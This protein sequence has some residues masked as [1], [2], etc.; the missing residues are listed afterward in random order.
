VH[1][2]AGP[3]RELLADLY[4]AADLFVTAS[5]SHFETFGRAPAE[6]L[7]CGLPVVAP[8]YDGFAEVLAQPGGTLVDVHVDEATGVPH[9]AGELLL[10]AV[11]DVLSSPRPPRDDV[12]SAALRRFG[13]SG[14]IRLL[15]YLAG[16]PSRDPAGWNGV[17]SR[18]ELPRE[19]RQPLA[20]MGTGAPV[21]ALRWFWHDCDQAGLSSLTVSSRCASAGRCACHRREWRRS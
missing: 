8:R 16:E 11:Y 12:A 15:G 13:R 18:V 6:A 17:A 5:T 4:N 19:W 20:Q 9:L 2:V 21:D 1:F 7:A 14:T 10:R 3:A